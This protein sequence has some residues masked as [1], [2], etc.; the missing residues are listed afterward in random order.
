MENKLKKLVFILL[1]LALVA[2]CSRVVIVSDSLLFTNNDLLLAEIEDD[3]AVVVKAIIEPGHTAYTSAINDEIYGAGVV[4]AFGL[5]DIVVFSFGTNEAFNER[6]VP[7]EDAHAMMWRLIRQAAEAGA[8]CVIVLEGNH[9]RYTDGG[10][11]LDRWFADMH[12][13]EGA[14]SWLGYDYTFLVADASN[15]PTADGVHFTAEGTTLAGKTI[16]QQ[17]ANCPA[18]R[19]TT[20]ND[21]LRAG[22]SL[23]PLPWHER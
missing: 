19:W 10:A 1:V 18:G 17:M 15:A 23:A 11:F 20:T 13:M 21:G 16:K 3:L 7:Y 4:A 8:R 5:P 6:N 2:G 12:A 14:R 9:L 22:E